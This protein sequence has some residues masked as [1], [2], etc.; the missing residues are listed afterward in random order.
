MRMEEGKS[1]DELKDNEE[2]GEK[3]EKQS[4]GGYVRSHFINWD[5]RVDRRIL[6]TERR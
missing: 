1:G 5:Y 6:Q 4:S 3:K 2:N